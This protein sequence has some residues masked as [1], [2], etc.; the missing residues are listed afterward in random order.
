M[1]PSI[2]PG[3]SAIS[4]NKS[5][6]LTFP[7][8][9]DLL[10]RGVPDQSFE[11]DREILPRSDGK[12][13][14]RYRRGFMTKNSN[15]VVEVSSNHGLSWKRIKRIAGISNTQ[16][17]AEASAAAV[18]L[19]ASSQPLRIRFR[20]YTV[21]SSIYTQEAAPTSPTGIFIDDITTVRC[22]ELVRA[23]LNSLPL[24]STSFSFNSS[25]AGADLLQGKRWHLR[26]RTILGGKVFRGP[27]KALT[28]AAP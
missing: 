1:R 22:D 19:P 3:F 27:G 6:H 15:L 13:K 28:I 26:L 23:K 5:F 2:Y 12:L 9:Y 10:A 16:I 21:G 18:E 4:G 17:D 7:N 14:F 24:D 25:S 11:I 8:S 20:Y